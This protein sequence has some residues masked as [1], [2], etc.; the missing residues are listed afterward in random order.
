MLNDISRVAVAGSV[1]VATNQSE[2]QLRSLARIKRAI[3]RKTNGGVQELSVQLR[4]AT[5]V[6]GGQ[7]SSF[8]CKQVAQEA[9]MSFLKESGEAIKNEIEVRP[10]H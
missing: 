5:F 4:G 10:P 1:I 2:Q 3:R 8:Y 6:L 9:A 7:C